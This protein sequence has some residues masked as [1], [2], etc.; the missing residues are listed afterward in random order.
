MKELIYLQLCIDG[1]YLAIKPDAD[2]AVRQIE[3]IKLPSGDEI[4]QFAL[5][6]QLSQILC[7]DQKTLDAI[8]QLENL[9]TVERPKMLLV[10]AGAIFDWPIVR[11]D[12]VQVE[13]GFSD[14]LNVIEPLE[15]FHSITGA[16]YA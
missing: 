12:E 11:I 9:K 6:F 5:S 13:H 3:P 1:E 16:S 15:N 4:M 10:S 2:D 7:G 8:R 14:N